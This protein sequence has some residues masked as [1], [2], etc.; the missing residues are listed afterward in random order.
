MET[1]EDTGKPKRSTVKVVGVTFAVAIIV[2]ALLFF[3]R[4]NLPFNS[5]FQP[6]NSTETPFPT[7]NNQTKQDLLDYA[8]QLINQ[9]RQTQGLQNVSLSTIDSGQQHADDLLSGGYL[10]HWDTNGYKPYLRYTLAGG[11]GAVEE[12]C[13]W[14]GETGNLLAIDVKAALKDLEYGMVYD[15]ASSNWG[16]RDNILNSLHN[17]VSIGIA[18]D[19]SN[20]YLV[21]DFEDDYITWSQL[22]D[23]SNQVTLQGTLQNLSSTIQRVAIF[24][25]NVSALTVDQIKEPQYQNSY[26]AGTYVG[27]V[28]PPNWTA[29]SGVTVKA[30]TWSLSGQDFRIVFSLDKAISTYGGGWYTLYLETG[31]STNDALLTHS[32]WIS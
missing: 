24:Y 19:K 27:L 8:L 20:V 14:K 12:N 11:R 5:P 25:D 16:H 7:P 4:T 29:Q 9:D 23:D 31:S 28:L 18:Y 3:V 17:R 26:D 10:S 13:A 15:D 32:I 6:A 1:Q 2:I 30:D 21:Q 22:S